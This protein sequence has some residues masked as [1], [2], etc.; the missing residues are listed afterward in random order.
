MLGSIGRM[1]SSPAPFFFF[2][3]FFV[4]GEESG[5][6]RGKRE[7]WRGGVFILQGWSLQLSR[8]SLA[9]HVSLVRSVSLRGYFCNLS[10]AHL[11]SGV[12][13][14]SLSCFLFFSF[15]FFFHPFLR[16]YYFS[17]RIVKKIFVSWYY[18]LYGIVRVD[19]VMYLDNPFDQRQRG[20]RWCVGDVM[21]RPTRKTYTRRTSVCSAGI[22]QP[23]KA[24]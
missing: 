17:P 11:I 19:K 3:F 15:S 1:V 4:G 7:A 13:A 10:C 23:A 2:F 16:T 22:P 8:L 5:N 14:L 6:G 9:C 12:L 21:S 20:Q 18:Y 24:N